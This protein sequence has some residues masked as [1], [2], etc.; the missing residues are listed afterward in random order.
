MRDELAYKELQYLLL[1]LLII[2]IYNE[3]GLHVIIFDN[4]NLHWENTSYIAICIF[5]I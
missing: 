2:M 4:M 1:Y 5:I 3:N